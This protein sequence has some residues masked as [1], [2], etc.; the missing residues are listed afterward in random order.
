MFTGC[1]P[2]EIVPA[3]MARTE[4]PLSTPAWTDWGLTLDRAVAGER[5]DYSRLMEDTRPLER[6]LTS[7]SQVGPDTC[8]QSFL[9]RDARL[10]YAINCYNAAILRSVLELAQGDRPPSHLPG[11]L[12]TRFRFRI[13]GAL[14]TPRDLRRMVDQL[15]GD[16]WRV[17]LALCDGRLTGPP[18]PPRAF[19]PGLLDAQLN[20][21]VRKALE[22]PG[23]VRIDHGEQ[24]RLLLWHGL[25]EIKDRLVQ[26]YE[27]RLHTS[28]ASFLNV[29]LEWSDRSR[30]DLLNAAVGYQ[31]AALPQSDTVNAVEPPPP[32]PRQSLF[33][34]L[35]SFSFLRPH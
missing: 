16:D 17:R 5:V 27:R 3:E 35:K 21:T 31:V 18:L 33:S 20:Q 32:A 13:D 34:S 8:P 23:V 19:L 24:K 11:N 14:R 10:A 29:L 2:K 15:A 4:R 7:V 26:E 25:W 1:G 30:R 28:G 6:F 12:E 22:S 9:D